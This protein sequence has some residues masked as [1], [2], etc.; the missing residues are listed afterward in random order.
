MARTVVVTAALAFVLIAMPGPSPAQDDTSLVECV[1]EALR[2]ARHQEQVCTVVSARAEPPGPIPRIRRDRREG[3]L[4]A[5]PGHS[6][7]G[8][9]DLERLHC[10]H[11][12]C[13]YEGP[14]LTEEPDTGAERL[15]L[16]VEAWSSETPFGPGGSAAYRMCI[17]AER[18]ATD[19]EMLAILRSCELSR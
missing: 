8:A 14:K 10:W 13:S 9:A 18:D 5:T 15:C 1:K 2:A 7:I 11:E 12:R 4:T 3:C 17:D 19:D 16:V 6:F